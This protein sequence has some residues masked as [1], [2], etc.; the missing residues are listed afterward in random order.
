V[1]AAAGSGQRLRAGGPKAFVALGGEPLIAHALRAAAAATP[2][3]TLIVAAPPG[4]EERTRRCCAAALGER[5][6]AVL[7]GGRTRAESVAAALAEVESELV[8]VH[9][10]A[11]PLAAPALF[12]AIVA[13]LEAE[14]DADAVIAATPILDTVKRAGAGGGRPRVAATEPREEL[15]AAQTPQGFRTRALREATA[16]LG[17]GQ[18]TA[19]T[20]EAR[21]IELAGG[22]VLIEPAPA[23]NLKVTTPAD[24]RIAEALLAAGQ[25]V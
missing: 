14:R 15:W 11:R 21:L 8:L 1:I 12:E 2:I 6:V 20:D 22:T 25:R 4:E 16:S 9:D 13:R 18:V 17:A 3:G 23:E 7:A 10:A 5:E 24:L 19:A